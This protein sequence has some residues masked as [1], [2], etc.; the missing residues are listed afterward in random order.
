M[1]R[2]QSRLDFQYND[3]GRH[4]AGYRGR[5]RDCATRAIA[6]ATG[7]GYQAVYDAL[8]V[9][10]GTHAGRRRTHPRTGLRKDTVK[11]FL[12]ELGW[13]WNPTMHIGSGCQVHLRRGEL[14]RG[15]LIVA[16]SKHLCAVID[17]VLHDT[18]DCSRAGRRCVYGYWVRADS[19]AVPVGSGS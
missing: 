10:A 1:F 11:A 18:H 17:G 14:P 4:A 12:A 3:G 19:Y 13:V 2:F 15:R 16:V 9:A 7:F 6:I 5:A 8:A